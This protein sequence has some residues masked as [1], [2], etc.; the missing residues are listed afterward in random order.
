M[1]YVDDDLDIDT[2]SGEEASLQIPPLRALPAESADDDLDWTAWLDFPAGDSESPESTSDVATPKPV[3][4]TALP[5][6]LDPDPIAPL[7][8]SVVR[9]RTQRARKR[10][11][12][13][14]VAAATA[15]VV[16]GFV[17]FGVVV[18]SD[19]EPTAPPPLVAATNAAQAAPAT[20]CPTENSANRVVS[21]G[22][23]STIR[24]NSQSLP[25]AAEILDLEHAMYVGRSAEATRAVMASTAKVA[26][27]EATRTAIAAIPTG[28]EHCVYVVP[29]AP[30]RLGVTVEE[31]RPDQTVTTH[32]LVI[33]TARQP[34]G[35]RLITSIDAGAGAR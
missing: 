4:E 26:P 2:G 8:D 16:V 5:V 15:V 33:S 3:P 17:V 9:K 1:S 6:E 12:V 25:G 29:V 18:L 14:V 27:I 32:D 34:D 23:G 31:K 11:G 20:W 35:R 28:T 13:V 7:V 30:D 10:R 24:G 21:N 19:S 22:A